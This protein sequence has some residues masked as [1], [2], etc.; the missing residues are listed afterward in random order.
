[1]ENKKDKVNVVLVLKSGGDFKFD[2]L[3]LLACHLHK[4]WRGEKELHVYCLF[5]KAI[6]PIEL[7]GVT[8]LPMPEKDYEGWWSKINLFSPQIKDL[9]PFLYLDLDTA[10]VNDLSCLIPDETLAEEF[11]M[12]RDFYKSTKPASGMMWIP[13]KPELNQIWDDFKKRPGTIVKANRG[14]Q[15][16]I[17]KSVTVTKF[18]QDLFPRKIQTF[19]PRQRKW[20]KDVPEETAVVCFHGYPRI[21]QASHMVQWVCDYFKNRV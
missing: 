7:I 3:S 11:I 12:L 13:D 21:P 17:S 15:D 18:W 1:M 4:Q 10:I 16:F 19:K 8:L 20:L 5:D 6:K 2:D 14:D 9:K